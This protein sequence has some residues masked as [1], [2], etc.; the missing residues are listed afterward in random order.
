MMISLSALGIIVPPLNYGFPRHRS[1][2]SPLVTLIGNKKIGCF[3]WCMNTEFKIKL[4]INSGWLN[5]QAS[6]PELSK[7]FH[8]SLNVFVIVRLNLMKQIT[9]STWSRGMIPP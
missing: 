6:V 4:V 2:I 1:T 5:T 9:L 7:G 8:S 3:A